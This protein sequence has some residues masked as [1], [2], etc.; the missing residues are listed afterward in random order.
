MQKASIF[1]LVV[2]ILIVV[3]IAL[4]FYG[5]QIVTEG[6]ETSETDLE[7]GSILEIS[8]KL[9]PSI[10]DKGVFVVQIMEFKSSTIDARLFDSYDSQIVS[11]TIEKE[12]HEEQ[13]DITAAGQYKLI[14][15]NKGIEKYHV[16][17]V[18]GHLPDKSKFAVGLTGFYI[19]LVGLVGIVGVGVYAIKN[20]KKSN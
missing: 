5:S 20:R 13:F 11:K 4:S 7:A 6:L 16:I 9:D 17:G 19:L 2:G 8:A 1:L 10:S 18:L 15:E 14:I 12:S 3:G